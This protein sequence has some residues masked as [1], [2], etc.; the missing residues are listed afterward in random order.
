MSGV[1]YFIWDSALWILASAAKFFK[2]FR[3]FRPRRRAAIDPEAVVEGARL[4]RWKCP[5]AQAGNVW[6]DEA[7][8]VGTPGGWI[9]RIGG[10]IEYGN[11]ERLV[12]KRALDITPPGSLLLAFPVANSV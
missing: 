11:A 2:P 6:I 7:L 3:Q 5:I 9:S 8:L 12:C 4:L 10:M 1:K